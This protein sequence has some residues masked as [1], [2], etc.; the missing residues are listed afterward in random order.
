MK[1][2]QAC[3]SI[4]PFFG[5]RKDLQICFDPSVSWDG[6]TTLHPTCSM[7]GMQSEI[8]R[9]QECLGHTMVC[10][11]WGTGR[12]VGSFNYKQNAPCSGTSLGAQMAVVYCLGSTDVWLPILKLPVH[13]GMSDHTFWGPG[14]TLTG[15]QSHTPWYR[16]SVYIPEQ[17]EVTDTER[18]KHK[19]PPSHKNNPHISQQ[20]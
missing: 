3:F 8:W 7:V 15:E 4:F 10:T 1:I 12:L 17:D 5:D 2:A 20:P 6:C 13:H 11:F 19:P 16:V 14:L 18:R 9:S